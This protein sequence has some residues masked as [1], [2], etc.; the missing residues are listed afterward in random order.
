M[1]PSALYALS[2]TCG[3]LNHLLFADDVFLIANNVREINEML[4]EINA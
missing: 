4:Q 3:W 1:G 2:V